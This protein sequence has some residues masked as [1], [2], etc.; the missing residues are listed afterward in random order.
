MRL[1]HASIS[2]EEDHVSPSPTHTQPGWVGLL[3]GDFSP[4]MTDNHVCGF[5]YENV[6]PFHPGRLAHLLDERIEPGEFGTIVRSAGYCRFASEPNITAQWEH[7]GKMI[8]FNPFIDDNILVDKAAVISLGQDLAIIGLD[9]DIAALSL[10]LDEATLSDA[11]FAAGPMVWQT[12]ENPF[13]A[14]QTI[15]GTTE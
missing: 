12:F 8:A 3:N 15:T 7:V 1:H 4:H 10:A 11:E 6:R 14:R 2:A 13:P 5:R 9:I